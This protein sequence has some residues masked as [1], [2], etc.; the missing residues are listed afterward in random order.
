MGQLHRLVEKSPGML[1]GSEEAYSISIEIPMDANNQI[2]LHKEFM[3]GLKE[4]ELSVSEEYLDFGF[5]IVG[6]NSEN[7]QFT[8]TNRLQF[9]VYM[10]WLIPGAT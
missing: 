6:R 4:K 2:S 9:D 3:Q 10:L 8:V 1:T 7:R 5:G